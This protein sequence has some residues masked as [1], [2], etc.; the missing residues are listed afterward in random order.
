MLFRSVW[1]EASG[2]T[3]N[4]NLGQRCRCPEKCKLLWRGCR[5]IA[6]G[7]H[8]AF[9]NQHS[10]GPSELEERIRSRQGL[11][12]FLVLSQRGRSGAE[13]AVRATPTCVQNLERR[14]GVPRS[15]LTGV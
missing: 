9:A 14:G 15:R 1:P 10:H 13:S 3:R 12:D 6:Q 2:Q 7:W 4:R 11:F 8:R 5:V